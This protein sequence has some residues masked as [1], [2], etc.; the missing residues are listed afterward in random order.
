MTRKFQDIT[1]EYKD[2]THKIKS[3]N[4]FRLV[5]QLHEIIPLA[6]ILNPVDDEGKERF[7]IFDVC[8][9]FECCVNYAGGNTDTEEVYCELFG[10][11]PLS[12]NDVIHRIHMIVV[13]PEKY[14]PEPSKE[15][16]KK[17]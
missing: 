12:M 9:A 2:E 1:F 14:A 13:P 5:Q 3:N 15:D 17:K 4:V 6:S 8:E 7:S 11:N 10:D 16:L